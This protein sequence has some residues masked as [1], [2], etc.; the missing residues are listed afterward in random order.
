MIRGPEKLAKQKLLYA[1]DV[2]K[3]LN[4]SKSFA[5][6]LMSTNDI[7]TVKIGKSVRVRISDLNIFVENN[8][9]KG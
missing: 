8:V 7:S 1:R 4:I 3:I 2:A 6:K 9:N 5:Y